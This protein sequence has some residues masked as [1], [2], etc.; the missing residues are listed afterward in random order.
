MIDLADALGLPL[1]P[2]QEYAI[3]NAC[4]MR[5][6]KWAANTVG[7]LVARQ[8]GKTHLSRMRI[9]TGL[10]VWGERSIIAM[11]QNRALSLDTF[12]KVVEVVDGTPWLRQEV[13]RISKTNG[14]EMLELKNGAQYAIVAANRDGPRGRTADLL[15]VDELREIAEDAWA[16]ARPMTRATPN[17]QTW[18]TSNAGDITSTVLNGLRATAIAGRTNSLAWM[19]WSADP[20]LNIHNP[21]AWAQANPALGH[22]IDIE[23]IREASISDHPDT[24]RTETLCQWV[25]VL[26]S[27]WPLDAW[28]NSANPDYRLDPSQP[29]WAGLDVSPD[30]RTAALVAVQELGN[31]IGVGLIQ[32]WATDGTIDDHQIAADVSAWAK[33][34]RVRTIAYDR[35]TAAGVAARLVNAGIPVDDT[36]G[37]TFIQACDETLSAL[38]HGR[39]VHSAQ[40]VLTDHMMSCAR[41]PAGDGGWRIVRRGSSGPIAGAVAMVMACHHASKP[42]QSA[43]IYVN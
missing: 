34:A 30:R 11:S 43:A 20:A 38:A 29:V 21:K 32:T 26:D 35:W 19:E 16:A 8:S 6:N 15:Y 9:I 13:K 40:Q 41:R 23:T 7:V 5:G 31:K 24:F 37:A 1:L 18:V 27:P 22:L 12:R 2:W 4:R 3:T 25:D 39:I 42:K 14:Q 33:T 28:H 36:S 17:P 10:F